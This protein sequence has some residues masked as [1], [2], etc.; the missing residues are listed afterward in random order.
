M[1][2]RPSTTRRVGL[3]IAAT[4]LALLALIA[5]VL[6]H[7]ATRRSG[8]NGVLTR[9]TV[10]VPAGATLCQPG[11]VLPVDTAALRVFASADSDAIPRLLVTLRRHGRLLAR[12]AARISPSGEQ[13]TVPIPRTTRD[14]DDV[15]ACFAVRA[16][17]AGFAGNVTQGGEVSS[18]LG[19]Q[20]TGSSVRIDYERPG[21]E[22]WWAY[23]PTIV[24]RMGFGRGGWGGPWIVGLI[25][26][27]V[28]ASLTLT[29]R[30]L[31]R[32]V[33]HEDDRAPG[34]APSGRTR[35]LLHR[36]PT[37]ARTLACIGFLNAAA[38][39]II[40][41][42]LLVPD[43]IGHVAYV[44]QVGETGRPPVPKG[45]AVFSPEENAVVEHTLSGSLI[46]SLWHRHLFTRVEERQLRAVLRL[47]LRQRGNG[48]AEDV[49]PE[50]P[51]FYALEAVPYRLAHGGT[52]LER[53]ALM[54]LLSAAL[55][56]A[57]TLLVF[58]FVRECLPARRWAWSVG[59]LGAAF[60]PM[61]GF[62]SGGVNP[63]ALLFPISAALLYALA[64]AFRRGLTRQLAVAVGIVL[65]L[66]VIAKINFYGLIPGALVA[67]LLAARRSEGGWSVGVARRVAPA[68]GVALVPFAVM[69][70][71]EALVWDRPFVL[72]HSAADAREYR[73]GLL[74]QL[75]F[76][77]QVY[78]PPLPGQR[79]AFPHYIGYEDWFRSFAGN[80][81][82]LNVPYAEWA[83]KVALAVL[84]LVGAL[85]LRALVAARATV[86]RR[87][88]ELV[89]YL[90]L[91]ASL[92]AL[93]AVVA[94]RGFTPGI[95]AAAQGRYL[96]PLLGLFAALLALAARGAGPRW[97][98]PV[99]AVIVVLL[100]GWSVFGQLVAIGGFYG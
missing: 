43:E 41:P 42:P 5:L 78:L 99:G 56:G 32:T 52:L 97:E 71:L 58:L 4:T 86:H 68:V 47:P 80:F 2:G 14:S 23:A 45:G 85:A 79:P 76:L 67:L 39:S 98:R 89:G 70:A 16:G 46:T 60:L 10:T 57:T 29:G 50:P 19:G 31:L 11:E 77:W 93:I 33:A 27:L 87:A 15:E 61:L 30:V 13:L 82:W 74:D 28:L 55:G 1:L 100:V 18:V 20:P 59:A 88:G 65:G 69:T 22:S 95:S 21:R 66:G 75:S 51:L 83:Y 73:G 96:L 91:V 3:S 6:S 84:A 53:I 36:V 7:A 49:D 54:R 63:D 9:D 26:G 64:R 12:A 92:L 37:T 48:D 38:W 17:D 72:G 35:A 62:I 90:S 34:A 8:S 44:Q 94:L 25:A 40:T 81:G 24:R